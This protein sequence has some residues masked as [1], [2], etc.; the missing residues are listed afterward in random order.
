MCRNYTRTSGAGPASPTPSALSATQAAVRGRSRALAYPP[1]LA[2]PPGRAPASG[3]ADGRGRRRFRDI[4]GAGRGAEVSLS[5]LSVCLQ[6]EIYPAPPHAPTRRPL[7][8]PP[9]R[10]PPPPFEPSRPS[11]A[12]RRGGSAF[13]RALPLLLAYRFYEHVLL[14]YELL[15][16]YR[17]YELLLAYRCY[18]HMHSWAG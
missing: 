10:P 4:G 8:L 3:G 9:P 13:A 12:G 7:A 1:G 5:G 15:L 6:T 16:A 18:D 14:G 17:C 2:D 11:T